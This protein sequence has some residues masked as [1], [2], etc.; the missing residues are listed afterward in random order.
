MK[1]QHL[2]T[3]LLAFFFLGFA[4]LAAAAVTSENLSGSYRGKLNASS[5]VDLVMKSAKEIGRDGSYFAVLLQKDS[6]TKAKVAMYIVDVL[7]TEYVMNPLVVTPQGEVSP[8]PMDDSPS[9]V[10][11][12]GARVGNKPTL[13]I[14]NANSSNHAG[15]QGA[16]RFEEKGS[17]DVE[18]SGYEPGDYKRDTVKDIAASLFEMKTKYQAD[19]SFTDPKFNGNF[20]IRMKRPDIFALIP[21][22][23]DGTGAKVPS[24]PQEIGVFLKM[25]RHRYFVLVNPM[26][27][28]D[29]LFY[30]PK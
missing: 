30:E 26:N 2:K 24:S 5:R 18:W 25:G 29:V 4:Q 20:K 17:S 28:S 21:T 3:W 11:N 12:V 14:T 10:L 6:K 8:N 27:D 9:L 16:I 13:V 1:T 23:H 19:A 22:V 7:D 15:F